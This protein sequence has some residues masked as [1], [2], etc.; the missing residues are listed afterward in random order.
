MDTE[1]ILVSAR[2]PRRVVSETTFDGTLIHDTSFETL[3]SEDA[4]AAGFTSIDTIKSTIFG[5]TLPLPVGSQLYASYLANWLTTSGRSAS[6]SN[7]GVLVRGKQYKG[8]ARR[9]I[10][11][12]RGSCSAALARFGTQNRHPATDVPLH[13]SRIR[14]QSR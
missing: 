5:L 9:L 1:S 11:R 10:R 13:H 7:A 14:R 12:H 8:H 4:T 6:L 2:R 3:T